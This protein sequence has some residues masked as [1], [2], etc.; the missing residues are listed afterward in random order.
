MADTIDS[1][2]LPRRPV[3]IWIAQ[4]FLLLLAVMFFVIGVFQFVALASM[5][6]E[7]S[8]VYLIVPLVVSVV[9]V[10]LPMTA[11][12]GM[13]KRKSYGRWLGASLIGVMITG[14]IFNRIVNGPS[15]PYSNTTQMLSGI[16]TEVMLNGLVVILVL[17]IIFNRKVSRFFSSNDRQDSL[18]PFPP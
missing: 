7:M 8:P 13:A 3:T 5:G 2:R 10:A 4:G 18:A 14:S 1:Q 12:V 11:F 9:F 15:I 6:N 16:A 17:S